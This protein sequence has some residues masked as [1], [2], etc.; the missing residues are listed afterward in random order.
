MAVST[1]PAARAVPKTSDRSNELTID[2]SGALRV[3]R[4][5]ATFVPGDDRSFLAAY[6][7]L[8]RWLRNQKSTPQIELR[9][10]DIEMLAEHLDADAAD[11]VERL[12]S[13]MG[14][15]ISQRRALVAMFATGAA[16]LCLAAG[17]GAATGGEPAESPSS[18]S[19]AP[20]ANGL[21]DSRTDLHDARPMIVIESTTPSSVVASAAPVPVVE[22]VAASAA[23]TEIAAPSAAG[24]APAVVA[25]VVSGGADV[26]A[27]TAP[28]AD[29]VAVGEPPVP[30]P[31]AGTETEA[32]VAVGEPPV[33]VQ[34]APAG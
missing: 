13:L 12:G 6:L 21:A 5:M 30:V 15:T 9:R 3:G 26:V 33:P 2:P 10:I 11:I 20:P 7:K 4:A 31:P 19:T 18:V 1:W 32:E 25:P 28:A 34:P 14:A 24:Q 16:V 22:P 23:P 27:T 29:E 17:A 8:V